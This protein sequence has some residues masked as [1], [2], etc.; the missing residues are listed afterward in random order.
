M[1]D[2][3]IPSVVYIK[4]AVESHDIDEAVRAVKR[5]FDVPNN[6][7]WLIIYDNYDNPILDGSK[8]KRKNTK[9]DIDG[10]GVS[11]G[12]DIRMFLPDAYHGAILITTGSS[13]IQ[14]AH[15]ILLEKLKHIV[16][17]LEIL[18]HTS[19]R[20]D[21][22]RGKSQEYIEHSI[23]LTIVDRY[24]CRRICTEI[25][26]TAACSFHRWYLFI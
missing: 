15:R 13:R 1:R 14:F 20:Q 21:L 24:C 4:N 10:D 7:R 25:R 17:S 23:R 3:A 6:N 22:G 9:P 5:W 26:W 19:G 18:S 8:E 16:E 11:E 2:R 12:Y